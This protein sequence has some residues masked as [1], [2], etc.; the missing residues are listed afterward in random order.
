MKVKII[1]DGE[2]KEIELEELKNYTSAGISIEHNSRKTKSKSSNE[3]K[4]RITGATPL[5][6]TALYLLIGFT[7]H[8]WHP[9][10]LLFLLIPLVPIIL[11]SFGKGKKSI[12][13]IVTLL[14]VIGYFILGSFGLWHP[15]WIIFFLI[16]IV[17]V[18]SGD[19]SFDDEDDD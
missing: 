15:G 12:T 14:T 11:Y 7:T 6:V 16:P 13:G 10:W 18:L 19:E 9:T 4:G 3:I 1:I 2:E 8:V 5:I 17:V